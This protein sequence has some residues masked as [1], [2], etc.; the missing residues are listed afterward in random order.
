MKTRNKIAAVA[1]LGALSTGA[2]AQSTG[3]VA[4]TGMILPTSCTITLANGGTVDL[5]SIDAGTLLPVGATALPTRTLDAT[6]ACTG[7][8]TL[9]LT[10]TDNEHASAAG[11]TPSTNFGLGMTPN[12]EKIGY[13]N[14]TAANG[15]ADAVATGLIASSN[16][17]TWVTGS[18]A[19]EKTNVAGSVAYQ[20][21][22]TVAAGP[23]Q[24]TNASFRFTVAAFLR[25]RSEMQ[26]TSD[27]PIN[28]SATL[29]VLYL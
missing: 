18:A 21:L 4:L 23:V 13:Y 12:N 20:A 5:G 19:W 22:G 17:T 26:L 7:P 15:A 6:L 10:S 11:S 8:T 25:G 27:T 3:E 16:L 29:E 9:A 1:V 28:G 14:L 2:T 24:F